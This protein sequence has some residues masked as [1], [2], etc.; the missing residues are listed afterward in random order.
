MDKLIH[1]TMKV[2][3]NNTVAKRKMVFLVLLAVMS[4]GFSQEIVN[5]N[6][7]PQNEYQT[8]ITLRPMCGA[9]AELNLPITLL[10]EEN[11]LT[12]TI[13]S[14]KNAGERFI[15]SFPKKMFYKDVKKMQKEVWFDKALLKKCK[16]KGAV[17]GVINANNLVNI[18]VIRPLEVVRV[19]EFLDVFS[20]VAYYFEIPDVNQ[21]KTREITISLYVASKGKAKKD[22]DKNLKNNIQNEAKRNMRVEY[23]AKFTLNI[24]LQN[25]CDNPEVKGVVASL[26]S[27]AA[28]MEAQKTKAVSELEALPSLNCTQIR[29]LT[30]MPIGKEEVTSVKNPQYSGCVNLTAAIKAYNAALEARNTA[31]RA[32]NSEL[33]D[34]KRK[35]CGGAGTD[36]KALV[37]AN[38]KLAEILLDLKNAKNKSPYKQE[39]DKIKKTIEADPELKK[40]KEYKIFEGLC[41]KVEARF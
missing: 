3:G 29:K 30:E 11:E 7:F 22:L 19:I 16:T 9:G 33:S 21:E 13:K 24:T 28:T 20:K 31:I 4:S 1:S 6:L 41:K 37:Q 5:V 26:V 39:Y 40:C 32:Y 23:L 25:V 12:L 38:E 34:L 14:D 15:Y 8:T 27:D 17:E 2:K 35:K 10:W 18:K 36:C